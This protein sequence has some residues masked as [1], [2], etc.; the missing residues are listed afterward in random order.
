MDRSPPTDMD[1]GP[2]FGV[3]FGLPQ[4]LVGHRG[5]IPFAEEEVAEQVDDRVTLGPTE[6]AMRRLAGGVA[7]V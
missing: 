5:G 2:P 6:V 3:R 1:G 4:D 7:Q